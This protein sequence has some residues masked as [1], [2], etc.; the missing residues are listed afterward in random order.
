MNIANI[1]IYH[2]GLQKPFVCIYKVCQTRQKEEIHEVV[3]MYY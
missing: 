3:S 2:A 1:Y